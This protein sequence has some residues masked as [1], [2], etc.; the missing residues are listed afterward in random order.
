MRRSAVGLAAAAACLAAVF[1]AAQSTA[2]SQKA[3]NAKQ[4]WEPRHPIRVYLD[5]TSKD[6]GLR[7]RFA[8]RLEKRMRRI[9]DVEIVPRE[10]DADE[11]VQATLMPFQNEEQSTIWWAGS[12]SY[13]SHFTPSCDQIP[14]G[15][16][17]NVLDGSVT[18]WGAADSETLD[19]AADTLASNFERQEVSPFRN[20]MV[21]RRK[22][23]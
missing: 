20:V 18:I 16:D 3:N 1:A 19:Q 2:H 22:R 8:S 14:S 9:D 4:Y 23:K 7:D 13:I 21:L 17:L 12:V 15:P 5:V 6:E 11:V 10:T